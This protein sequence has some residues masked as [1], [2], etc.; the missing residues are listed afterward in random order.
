MTLKTLGIVAGCVLL[1]FV[2]GW[3]VGASGRS[4]VSLELTRTALAADATEIRASLLDARLSLAQSNFGDARRS[5]QRAQAASVRVESRLRELGE[6]DRAGAV[7]TVQAHL[8]EADQLAAALDP[9]ADQPA[10]QALR[11]LEASVATSIP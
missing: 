5:V 10:I 8:R 9:G 6:A 7:Q 1:A 4:A 11:T 3:Y 2:L